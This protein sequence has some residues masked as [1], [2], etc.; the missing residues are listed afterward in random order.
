LWS[1][2]PW[3]IGT[4][5]ESKA[6]CA[7]HDDGRRVYRSLT[8]FHETD[9]G[10]FH[11]LLSLLIL[12]V[13]LAFSAV[14]LL[15]WWDKPGGWLLV[16]ACCVSFVL[17]WLDARD[18]QEGPRGHATADDAPQDWSLTGDGAGEQRGSS[19]CQSGRELTRCRSR[20]RWEE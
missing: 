11:R 9:V 16:I 4:Q 3:R 10:R 13:A 14:G 8:E 1:G 5:C 15:A 19:K 12:A 6:F 18:A 17:L 2:S 20:D 7:P